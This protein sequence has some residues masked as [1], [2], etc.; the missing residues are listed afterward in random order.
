MTMLFL[1]VFHSS[2]DDTIKAERGLLV[3]EQSADDQQDP[4]ENGTSV[5]SLSQL[6]VGLCLIFVMPHDITEI[7]FFF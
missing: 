3:V 6:N 4:H 1:N 7:W 2:T 5:P